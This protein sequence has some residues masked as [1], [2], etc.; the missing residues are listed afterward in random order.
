[1]CLYLKYV[2]DDSKDELII[3]IS[4]LL[5][6]SAANWNVYVSRINAKWSWCKCYTV[7][8]CFT[9]LLPHNNVLIMDFI[10][11]PPEKSDFEVLHT[12]LSCR[13]VN[14]K[15][16]THIKVSLLYYGTNFT[17]NDVSEHNL[18]YNG[19]WCVKVIH[20]AE[21]KNATVWKWYLLCQ[22]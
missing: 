12:F 2:I 3:D 22:V 6:H 21:V 15:F 13:G 1:M 10:F 14:L 9:Q 4:T 20:K 5:H 7:A 17:D 19:E 8:I 18:H 11:H 16:E